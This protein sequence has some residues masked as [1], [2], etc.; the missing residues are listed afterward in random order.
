MLKKFRD[1]EKLITARKNAGTVI[2]VHGVKK[3]ADTEPVDW[4]GFTLQRNHIYGYIPQLRSLS[5]LFTGDFVACGHSQRDYSHQVE[6]YAACSTGVYFEMGR[7]NR[8]A[9]ESVEYEYEWRKVALPINS[10]MANLILAA[11]KKRAEIGE[12][13]KLYDRA[14]GAPRART[15]RAEFTPMRDMRIPM[16]SYKTE[17]TVS[18]STWGGLYK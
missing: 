17:P 15:P 14:V 4:H 12:S 7:C 10:K 1:D 13:V 9:S 3:N 11:F 2:R 16:G 5:P 8:T 18:Q 6:V